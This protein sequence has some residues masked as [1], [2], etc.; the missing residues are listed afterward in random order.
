MTT[1]TFSSVPANHDCT[2]MKTT[3]DYLVSLGLVQ[4]S[5]TGQLSL[6]SVPTWVNTISYDYGYTVY[7][8]NDALQAT[9]PI[10]LKIQWKNSAS[11]V[12]GFTNVITVG[13]GSNGSGTITGLL[14][15]PVT[16]NDTTATVNATAHASYMC[17]ANSALTV[18][19]FGANTNAGRFFSVDRMRDADGTANAHGVVLTTFARAGTTPTV[20]QS[21]FSV[22][23]GGTAAATTAVSCFV[24]YSYFNTFN[25]LD[26]AGDIPVFGHTF[27]TPHANHLLAVVTVLQADIAADTEFSVIRLGAS[28]TYRAVGTRAGGAGAAMSTS[29]AAT[30]STASNVLSIAYL[31]E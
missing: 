18:S 29:S 11:D 9:Y 17:Y 19:L 10:Y 24:P 12:D 23:G 25:T 1:A 28:H 27:L 21:F 14:V 5:D 20:A 6:A 15:G 26:L 16:L 7:R 4:T 3:H 8:W 31:Y 2:W 22:V 13:A 30:P